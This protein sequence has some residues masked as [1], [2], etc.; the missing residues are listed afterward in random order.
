MEVPFHSNGEGEYLIQWQLRLVLYFIKHAMFSGSL[1][2]Y[3]IFCVSLFLQSNEA[4]HH[5]SE[6]N[7]AG[8]FPESLG[9]VYRKHF[10]PTTVPFPY[11]SDE[12]RLLW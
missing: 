11:A 6:I 1:S 9:R 5:E 10:R 7:S 8:A 12:T 4:H 2:H 3:A